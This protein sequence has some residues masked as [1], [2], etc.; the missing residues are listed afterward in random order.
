MEY[1]DTL[2][3][4]K[5]GIIVGETS[6]TVFLHSFFADDSLLGL[7]IP[8]GPYCVCVDSFILLASC[9]T[10]FL[11]IVKREKLTFLLLDKSLSYIAFFLWRGLPYGICLMAF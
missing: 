10:R 2:L 3:Y 11:Q 9:R 8:K 5:S 6:D 7:C 4:K 1:L